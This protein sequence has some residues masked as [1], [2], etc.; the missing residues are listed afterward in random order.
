MAPS[1]RFRER[2]LRSQ[3]K[4]WAIF[5]QYSYQCVNF[6]PTH[7]CILSTKYGLNRAI[8]KAACHTPQ[9]YTV[10]QHRLP[11]P[12]HVFTAVVASRLHQPM[13][14]RVTTANRSPSVPA[15]NEFYRPRTNKNSVNYD[16]WNLRL[17]RWTHVVDVWLSLRRHYFPT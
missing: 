7:G 15:A 1:Y 11:L 14:T 13:L 3:T 16:R 12:S 2:T 10:Y 6:H 9:S 5:F 4:C 8:S 17:K